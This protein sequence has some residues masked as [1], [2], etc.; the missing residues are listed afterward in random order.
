MG[1][2][3]SVDLYVELFPG[4]RDHVWYRSVRR[5]CVPRAD[6]GRLKS[7]RN[8]TLTKTP[9]NLSHALSLTHRGVYGTLVDPSVTKSSTQLL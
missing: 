3:C 9:P 4:E 7:Y 1:D 5:R 6:S 2:A 8:E